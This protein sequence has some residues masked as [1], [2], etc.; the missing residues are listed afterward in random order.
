M[1]RAIL[2]GSKTHDRRPVRVQLPDGFAPGRVSLDWLHPNTP[3]KTK[4]YGLLLNDRAACVSP[5]GGPGDH[6]WV[7]E[8]FADASRI[9]LSVKRVW[10]ECLLEISAEDAIREGVLLPH[11]CPHRVEC[12]MPGSV[13]VGSW[14]DDM[15]WA[16][17]GKGW[18]NCMCAVDAFCAG[19]DS[20]YASKGYGSVTGPVVWGCEFERGEET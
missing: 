9:K 15:D 5:F 20:V 14:D 18:H 19:W 4:S 1:V 11:D 7:R 13:G 12:E 16:G 17:G 6:V 2:D 3:G 10:I 8:C